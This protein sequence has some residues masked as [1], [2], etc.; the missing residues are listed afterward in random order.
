[1]Q[2]FDIGYFTETK[3]IKRFILNMIKEKTILSPFCFNCTSF[4]WQYNDIHLT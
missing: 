2:L 1:M 4:Q 3:A